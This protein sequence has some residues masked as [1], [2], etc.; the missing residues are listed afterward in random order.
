MPLQF[1][2]SHGSVVLPIKVTPRANKSEIVG[3]EGDAIK[4][5]LKA[6][7]V[8]GKANEALVRFIAEVFAV[9]RASVEIV[10]GLT[11]RRK[12]VSV[13]GVSAARAQQL[14]LRTTERD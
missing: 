10:S 1:Q 13:R 11:A 5:R 7:P 12:L 2:E 3:L 4:V 9:P 8:D 14:L 6:P